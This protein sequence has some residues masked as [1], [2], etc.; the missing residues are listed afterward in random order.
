[1]MMNQSSID[2]FEMIRDRFGAKNAQGKFREMRKGY[3]C[4]TIAGSWRTLSR[5][6]DAFVDFLGVD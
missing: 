3:S 1:M 5:S 6:I 2:H 4:V